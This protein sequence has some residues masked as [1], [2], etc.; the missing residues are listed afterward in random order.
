TL[1]KGESYFYGYPG[2]IIACTANSQKLTLE[3]FVEQAQKSEEGTVTLDSTGTFGDFD[4]QGILIAGVSSNGN[5]YKEPLS[6]AVTPDGA[7]LLM[8]KAWSGGTEQVN[9]E[10]EAI[11]N[12]LKAS[13]TT[14]KLKDPSIKTQSS[15]PA[16]ASCQQLKIYE[17]EFA[18]DKCYSAQDYKDL[19]YYLQAYNGAIN[20]YNGS[21]AR[22][23]IVCNGS[24]FFKNNCTEAQAE[25]TDSEGKISQYK[26]M[27]QSI[28]SRGK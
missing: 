7:N 23:N 13:G 21:V 26:G 18:S 28:M 27:I 6:L 16:K 24:E 17:G 9:Q 10:V 20:S 15:S 8:I 19:Q 12:G 11:G 3:Q 1:E 2:V 5:Y 22:I 14:D 4:V 25:K